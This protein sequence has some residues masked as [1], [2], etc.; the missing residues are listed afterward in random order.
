MNRRFLT[1]SVFVLFGIVFTC[2]DS[3][4]RRDHLF[5]VP[6]IIPVITNHVAYGSNIFLTFF[7]ARYSES[8]FNVDFKSKLSRFNSILMGFSVVF[9]AMGVI[10][11]LPKLDGTPEIVNMANWYRFV[12]GFAIELYY[13][14]YSAALFV[15]NGKQL[16]K[17]AFRTALSSFVITM[18]IITIEGFN[19]T[20]IYLN[21]LGA[22]L[23]IY[24]FYVG[25]ESS[26]YKYLIKAMQDLEESKKKADSAN[27]SKS[28]FLA[29]MSHEIRTPLNA[30][31]GMNEMILRESENPTV[32]S[33]ARNVES[34][35][36]NLLSIINDILDFSKIEAGKL[37]LVEAPYKLSSVINDVI[38]IISIKASSKEIRFESDVDENLPDGLFGD[39]VR[40]RQVIVNILSNAVKYTN[41]G[42]VKFSITG[43]KTPDNVCLIVKVTDSGIGIKEEDLPKIFGKFERVDLGQNKTVEGTGLGL[44]ITHSL[45]EMMNGNIEVESVYG[46]GSTFTI[47]IPQKITLDEPIGDYRKKFEMNAKENN[48]YKETFTAPDAYIL[49]VDDMPMNLTVIT[50][51]LAKTKIKIDTAKSGEEALKLTQE[52]PYDLILMDQMMPQMDGSQ[53]LH[54]IR[55]QVD[56]ANIETP[57]ICLTADAISGAKERYLTEGFTDYISKPVKG[58]ALEEV[59]SEYL[60]KEKVIHQ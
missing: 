45:L 46:S 3:I 7:F 9:L 49:V 39:E 55:K 4:F 20:G 6:Q 57:M 38:N 21:Y 58:Y 2:L 53:V 16:D 17:R 28:D 33:Y 43:K 47:M 40:I 26:D 41:K 10:F 31:I 22:V 50:R 24:V 25:N 19:N 15:K 18:G 23:G 11:K 42:F 52:I 34:A 13:L 37:E 32:I 60:P 8:F 36:N 59:L 51:L 30:V 27:R 12:T 5:D 44:A 54:R 14:G 48:V 1:L 56:G 35:G 29:S